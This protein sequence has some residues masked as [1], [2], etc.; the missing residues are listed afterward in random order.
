M[1]KWLSLSSKLKFILYCCLSYVLFES[2]TFSQTFDIS[3]NFIESP[4]IFSHETNLKGIS[5]ISPV[6][7][8]FSK[9]T[10]LELSL[11]KSSVNYPSQWLKD[12]IFDELGNIA[13]TERLLRS[14][15]S[16]LSDPIFDQFKHLPL[17]INDTIEQLAINP[18]VFCKKIDILYNAS[19]KFYELNC[20]IPFGFFNNYLIMRLQLKNKFWYFTKIT[21]LNYNRMIE[22][23]T[24]AETFKINNDVN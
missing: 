24:I 21:T 11:V 8:T 6:R 4:L 1:E 3:E 18:L 9:Y 14:K 22:L 13:E 19:G 17:Y 12:K 5:R 7:D 10:V 20:T 16:P 2:K 15:D 23:I